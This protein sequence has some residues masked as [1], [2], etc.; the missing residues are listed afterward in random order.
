MTEKKT[1]AS[2]KEAIP[3]NRLVLYSIICSLL[4]LILALYYAQNHV[5]RAE[6]ALKTIRESREEVLIALTDQSLNRKTILKFQ[7]KDPFFINKV[8]EPYHPL[9]REET[10]L[11][12]L[13]E[14]G[15][16][17]DFIQQDRRLK[18]LTCG[19]NTSGVGY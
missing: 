18:Y 4:P 13:Q 1:E 15:S 16:L 19:E 9:K 8:L 5:E 7:Q 2:P 11:K 14:L 6:N 3:S 10:T 17:P 12:E